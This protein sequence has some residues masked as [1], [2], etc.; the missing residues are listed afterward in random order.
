MLLGL[1]LE[2]TKGPVDVLI[3]DSCGKAFREL[4]QNEIGLAVQ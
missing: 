1:K 4:V 3:I 2:S